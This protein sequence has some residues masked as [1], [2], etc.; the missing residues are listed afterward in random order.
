MI[1]EF[2]STCVTV[3]LG[4]P[5]EKNGEILYYKVRM[6]EINFALYLIDDLLTGIVVA[7]LY[8]LSGWYRSLAHTH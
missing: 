5:T 6:L 4:E 7:L 1:P 2:N 8:W 3:N